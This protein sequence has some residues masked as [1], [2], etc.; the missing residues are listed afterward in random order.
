ML[1]IVNLRV[2][3]EMFNHERMSYQII[4]FNKTKSAARVRV[5]SYLVGR[6][7]TLVGKWPGSRE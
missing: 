3:K 7:M 2:V 1:L 5:E 6:I 4:D